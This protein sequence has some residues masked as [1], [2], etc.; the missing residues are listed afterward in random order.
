MRAHLLGISLLLGAVQP[1]AFASLGA[2]KTDTLAFKAHARRYLLHLPPRQDKTKRLPLVIA[3]H[4]DNG[5]ARQMQRLTGLDRLADEEGFFVVYP[6]GTGWGNFP[7]RGWNAGTCCGYAQN[8]KVDDA[9][10]IAALIDHLIK[11]QPVDARRVYA[12][13]I[14]NGAMM[15]HAATCALSDRIAAIAAV[16]GA[17]TVA[18]CEPQL[19]VSVIML[20]GTE[21]DYVPYEGGPSAREPD[22]RMDPSAHTVAAFWAEHNGCRTEP[23]RIEDKNQ[24]QELYPG[25][26]QGAV[27]VLHSLVGAGH[28]WPH[29]ASRLIWD[30]FARQQ[31]QE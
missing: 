26:Q 12:T 2:N 22:G 15:A 10:F 13:G 30:F 7:P 19:P 25:C 21:D 8:A 18:V 5:S 16:S 9:G 11:T 1:A 28:G 20:H 29:Q 17:L 24:I 6:E 31:R 27:V 4:G 14:S 23:K 3:L